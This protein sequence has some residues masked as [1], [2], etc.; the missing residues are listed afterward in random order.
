MTDLEDTEEFQET[1]KPVVSKQPHK[2]K[3]QS[4]KPKLTP[5]F[6]EEGLSFEFFFIKPF[7]SFIIFIYPS[8]IWRKIV[9]YQRIF[10]NPV[11][12]PDRT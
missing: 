4:K 10:Q 7:F 3:P 12:I 8:Q 1:M 6:E 11:P 5:S 2:T 9:I